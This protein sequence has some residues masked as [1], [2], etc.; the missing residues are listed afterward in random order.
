[1]GIFSIYVMCFLAI[2][3]AGLSFYDYKKRLPAIRF[4]GYYFLASFLCNAVALIF[5]YLRITSLLNLPGSIWDLF[6]VSLLT[7]IF[8]HLLDQKRF[9]LVIG[10]FVFLWAGFN[11][12]FVQNNG[13]LTTYSKTLNSLMGVTFSII[14]FFKLLRDMP[15]THLHRLPSFWIV[16]GTLLFSAGSTFLYASRQYIIDVLKDD[17]FIYWMFHNFLFIIMEIVIL[18]GVQQDLRTKDGVPA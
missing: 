15:T 11:V 16:S 4:V 2:L 12:V 3:I 18:I 5:Y 13:E 17:V 7:V 10:S 8:Y 14:Y 6:Q 9:V 1:M